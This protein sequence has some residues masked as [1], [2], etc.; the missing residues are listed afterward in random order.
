MAKLLIVEGDS[1]LGR[2]LGGLLA[3]EVGEVGEPTVALAATLDEARRH[4]REGGALDVALIAQRLPDGDGLALLPEI[5]VV[6][7][8]PV[9]PDLGAGLRRLLGGLAD[10]LL[11]RPLRLR[12]GGPRLGERRDGRARGLHHFAAGTTCACTSYCRSFSKIAT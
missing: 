6:D 5:R 12:L 9:E 2:L 10:E 1:G 4:L 8:Q 3:D 7:P 11:E